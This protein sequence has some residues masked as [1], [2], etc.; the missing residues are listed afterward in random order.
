MLK[1]CAVTFS[2]ST[3]LSDIDRPLGVEINNDSGG[4]DE[5]RT[6]DLDKLT[7]DRATEATDIEFCLS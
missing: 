2:T 6:G 7:P 5:V 1:Q 3:H 4:G